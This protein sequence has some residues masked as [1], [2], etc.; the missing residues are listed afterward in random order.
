MEAAFAWIGKIM[1]WFGQFFPRWI[2]V[3]PMEGYVKFVRGARVVALAP[4]IHWYWPVTTELEMHPVVRQTVDLRAQTFVTSDGKTVVAG[5]LVVYEVH[6]IV[7]CITSMHMPDEAVRDITLSAIH[8]ICCDKTW[9]ALQK[10][11][12]KLDTEMK[13]EAKKNLLEYGI[14]VVKVALTD[15]APCRVLK[16]MHDTPVGISHV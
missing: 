5:G 16:L 13:N 8:D 12:R 3:K 10:G 11:G 2:I 4:G 14:T 6:D 15:L 9:D 1:D 7:L